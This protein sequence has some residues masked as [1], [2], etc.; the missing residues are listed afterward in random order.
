V[1][2][3]GGLAA[4]ANGLPTSVRFVLLLL[5][6]VAGAVAVGRLLHPRLAGLHVDDRGV[7]VRKAGE[8]SR[9]ARVGG[10]PFVS[11]LYVGFRLRPAGE[12]FPRSV[13]VF[14]GQMAE[15]DF[16]RLS[17]ALRQRGEA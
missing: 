4:F 12:R 1:S 7:R 9:L 13:G 14:R 6:L 17:V 8:P 16:R 5:V 15:D 3:L 11:P 2:L 10:T